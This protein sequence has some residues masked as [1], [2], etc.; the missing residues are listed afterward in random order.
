MIGPAYEDVATALA[1]LGKYRVRRA[2]T[3]ALQGQPDGI[4]GALVLAMGL[5]ETWGRNIEGGAKRVGTV[6]VALDP[7]KPSE[8]RLMD[9]SWLQISRVY[10]FDALS[11][12]LA[13]KAGTWDEAAPG[14]S[15]AEGGY[16]PRFEEALQFTLSEMHEAMA[17]AEDN[18]IPEKDW[19][20]FA[21][22][23]HNAGRSDALKGYRAGD[24][25]LF[26]AG[27]DYSVWVLRARSQVN[28]W[29]GE[30]RKWLVVP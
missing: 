14:H 5:R 12:M 6:Y 7:K 1:R 29:L 22:A 18:G 9:V 27:G 11:R 16:V 25:D 28:A 24:V 26:T 10:H 30:H 2:Q 8:A 23:A 3:V 4:S 20:R 13:V 17:F 19:P 21:I 15:P